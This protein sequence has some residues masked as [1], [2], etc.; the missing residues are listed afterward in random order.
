MTR[1]VRNEKG[2]TLVELL[3]VFVISGMVVLLIIAIYLYVQNQ[4]QQQAEQS[5]QLTD[6]T[7]AMKEITKDIRSREILE[8]DE[9]RLTFTD[10]KT[11]ELHQDVLFRNDAPY[12]YKV[13][14]FV[15]EMIE[16]ELSIEIISLNGQEISTT[17][18][19]R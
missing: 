11:Y 4:F 10:G 3:A 16:D 14:R 6:V 7:I 9:A 5:H 15:I 12:I 19:V 8:W 13:D 18:I 17:L 1:K 2:M